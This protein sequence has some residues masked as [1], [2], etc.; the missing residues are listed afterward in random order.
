MSDTDTHAPTRTRGGVELFG[1]LFLLTLAM[2]L[3]VTLTQAEGE[4]RPAFGTVVLFV[5]VAR[6]AGL[7]L[8]L[9]RRA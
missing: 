4:F 6:F 2:G 5:C 1:R 9:G 3:A 8:G 7:A